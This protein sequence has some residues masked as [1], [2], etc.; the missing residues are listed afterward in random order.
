VSGTGDSPSRRKILV[1][2]VGNLLLRDEGVGVHAVEMLQ[3]AYAFSANVLVLDGGTL[4]LRLMD[5]MNGCDVLIVIDAVLNGGPPGTLYR[6]T[7][8]QVGKS[9]A[10]KNSLH[11]TD[12]VETL[13]CCELTGHRP[14]TIVIGVEPKDFSSWSDRLT[15][16][17]QGKLAAVVKEVLREIEAAGGTCTPMGATG[18]S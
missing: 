2:G 5:Y 14:E 4:G 12:L 1:L 7:G 9:R 15:E 11:Q 10:F 18:H 17:L 6:L 16:T 3:K 8:D 13:A